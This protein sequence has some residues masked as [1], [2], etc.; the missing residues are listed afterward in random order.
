[1]FEWL[2]TNVHVFR[3]LI[4]ACMCSVR[5]FA[6]TALTPFDPREPSVYLPKPSHL[7]SFSI[8]PLPLRPC[9]IRPA[10]RFNLNFAPA[11]P[12]AALRFFK[13]T[14]EAISRGDLAHLLER[15]RARYPPYSS[16]FR[17]NVFPFVN[18]FEPHRDSSF[19]NKY[20]SS[21]I[22]FINFI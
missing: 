20:Y 5:G 7:L 12:K 17:N 11:K 6:R 1:M 8:S 14:R 21:L 22:S 3:K 19:R 18:T 15:L 2:I 9:Y 13:V 10:P 16:H 4:K